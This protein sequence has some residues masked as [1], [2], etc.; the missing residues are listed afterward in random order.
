[1][2]GVV[3]FSG[4]CHERDDRLCASTVMTGLPD[5]ACRCEWQAVH[6]VRLLMHPDTHEGAWKT[7]PSF[8]V[9]ESKLKRETSTGFPLGSLL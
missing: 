3:P 2:C 7:N 4:C 1:M 5:I 9:G 8:L 6:S